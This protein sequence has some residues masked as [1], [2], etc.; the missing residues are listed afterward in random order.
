MNPGH[1]EIPAIRVQTA[2]RSAIHRNQPENAPQFPGAL[3]IPFSQQH[4]RL[5]HLS[6]VLKRQIRSPSFW[7]IQQF[8]RHVGDKANSGNECPNKANSKDRSPPAARE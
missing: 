3:D 2:I 8:N 4:A 5:I 7:R 1:P 6:G